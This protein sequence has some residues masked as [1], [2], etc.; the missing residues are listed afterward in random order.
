MTNYFWAYCSVSCMAFR[1]ISGACTCVGGSNR[2]FHF[3]SLV[4]VSYRGVLLEV[5]A[6]VRAAR[7]QP[8]LVVVD[9]SSNTGLEVCHAGPDVALGTRVHPRVSQNTLTAGGRLLNCSVRAS[10]VKCDPI[11]RVAQLSERARPPLNHPRP[12]A[13]RTVCLSEQDTE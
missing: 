6:C 5:Y 8:D 13:Q 2:S 12:M 9:A 3:I 4:I 1:D 11:S 7:R 10:P